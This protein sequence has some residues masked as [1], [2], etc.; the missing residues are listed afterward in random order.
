MRLKHTKELYF[1]QSPFKRGKVTCPVCGK[2]H[3]YHC[4]VTV[5]GSLALCKN[6]WSERQANDGRFIHILTINIGNKIS[7]VSPTSTNESEIKRADAGKLHA[8]YTALLSHLT[9]TPMH[10]NILLN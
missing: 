5:D 6:K 3:R 1:T 8:V 10:G 2:T 4:S 7:A 9:L